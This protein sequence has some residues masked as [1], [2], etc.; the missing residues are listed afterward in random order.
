MRLIWTRRAIERWIDGK[1]D[2]MHTI[3]APNIGEVYEGYVAQFTKGTPW[4]LVNDSNL[5]VDTGTAGYSRD[6]PV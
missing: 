3:S 6:A 2:P 5:V 4:M 1:S